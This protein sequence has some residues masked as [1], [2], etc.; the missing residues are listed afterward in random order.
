METVPLV[1]PT[2]LLP[3]HIEPTPSY[4]ANPPPP[5][6]PPGFERYREA[7]LPPTPLTTIASGGSELIGK[8]YQAFLPEDKYLAT[9]I[10]TRDINEFNTFCNHCWYLLQAHTERHIEHPLSE[11]TTLAPDPIIF[12]GF[13][14]KYRTSINQEGILEDYQNIV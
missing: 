2:I 11:L 6:I 5:V 4:H 12:T 9:T 3:S 1:Y 10:P 8:T 7:L 13:L 14:W